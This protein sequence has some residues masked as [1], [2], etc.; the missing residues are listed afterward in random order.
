LLFASAISR[1]LMFLKLWTASRSY[2][3]P[4]IYFHEALKRRPSR[5]VA[6][7]ATLPSSDERLD[8]RQSSIRTR[9]HANTIRS[10]FIFRNRP[11]GSQRSHHRSRCRRTREPSCSTR[12]T[13]F[14]T[15][16]SWIAGLARSNNSPSN[17][18]RGWV[19]RFYS[20]SGS[21]SSAGS[22]SW[23]FIWAS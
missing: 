12:L 10:S 8:G 4:R 21:G 5:S 16:H 6:A 19:R 2:V 20:S 1:Y 15:G 18:G 22:G 3:P 17:R 13:R 9:S 23:S 7:V 14:D 11:K